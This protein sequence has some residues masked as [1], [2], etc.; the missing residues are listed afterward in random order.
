[1]VGEVKIVQQQ[2]DRGVIGDE[3]HQRLEDVDLV[4]GRLLCTQPELGQDLLEGG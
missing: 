1:M 2:H 3:R 4:E